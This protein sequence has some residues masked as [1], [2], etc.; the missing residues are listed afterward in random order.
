MAIKKVKLPNNTTLDIN[1]ARVV[2]DAITY[3]GEQ[4]GSATY[5]DGGTIIDV[6]A[7]ADKVTGATT[8]H[9]AGLDSNGNLTDSGHKHSDYQTANLV[10]SI[11]SSSTDTQ[12][13]SAKCVYDIVGDIETL[14]AAI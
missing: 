5:V 7:K 9:F 8:G 2:S 3:I 14:L 4:Q 10:T 1:D 13:P 11:S 6:T 12:Y